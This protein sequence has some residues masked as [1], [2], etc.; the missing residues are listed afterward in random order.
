MKASDTIS[1]WDA[2]FLWF[3]KNPKEKQEYG[4]HGWIVL[5]TR[6]SQVSDL[7]HDLLSDIERRKIPAKQSSRLH[8]IP[9]SWRSRLGSL[10]GDRDPR[11]TTITIGALLDFAKERDEKPQFLAHLM[12]DPITHSGGV[13]RPTSMHLIREEMSRRALEGRLAQGLA[14]EARYLHEWIK[15][16]HPNLATPKPKSIT[17]SLRHHYKALKAAPK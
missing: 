5:L 7:V 13:G 10:P 15:R 6:D 3:G 17:N 9:D 16:E 1:V 2:A 11:Y 12:A 8:D 4:L 14:E